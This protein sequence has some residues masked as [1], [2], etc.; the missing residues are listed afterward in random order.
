MNEYELSQNKQLDSYDVRDLNVNPVFP[1]PDSSFDVVTCVV[2]IDYL[3]QPDK[4]FAEIGRVLRPNGK[5]IISMS[6]RYAYNN[7][8]H[9]H[10]CMLHS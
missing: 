10:Y 6:N 2:S 7:T 3:N 8:V 5:V 4:I 1:Y 9:K